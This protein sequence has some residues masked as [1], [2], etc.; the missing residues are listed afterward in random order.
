ERQPGLGS[1]GVARSQLTA[2]PAARTID[3]ACAV[4]PPTPAEP[5]VAPADPLTDPPATSLNAPT[6]RAVTRWVAREHSA[7]YVASSAALPT[8]WSWPA[9]VVCTC[10]EPAALS[11]PESAAAPRGS[12]A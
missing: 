6:L 9:T 11:C 1:S 10:S 7:P 8:S 12:L 5:M 4:D 2:S 3:F